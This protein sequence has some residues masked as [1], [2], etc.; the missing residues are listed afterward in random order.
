[1]NEAILVCSFCIFG[2]A[3]LGPDR[4]GTPWGAASTVDRLEI[5]SFFFIIWFN[6]FPTESKFLFIRVYG[7]VVIFVSMHN[8]LFGYLEGS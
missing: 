5:A 1:M 3:T 2:D 6:A 7:T 4:K 8:N